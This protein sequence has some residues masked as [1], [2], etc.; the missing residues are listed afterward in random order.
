MIFEKQTPDVR[1]KWSGTGG[2]G[3]KKKQIVCIHGF[4]NLKLKIL[5]API[6]ARNVTVQ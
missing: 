6:R 3:L 5:N 1:P 2:R 4:C